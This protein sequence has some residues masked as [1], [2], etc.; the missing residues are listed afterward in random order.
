M[1]ELIL[2][3]LS[4]CDSFFKTSLFKFQKMLIVLINIIAVL[5]VLSSLLTVTVSMWQWF[6]NPR[7]STDNDG[8]KSKISRKF[9]GATAAGDVTILISRRSYFIC[10]AIRQ[11]NGHLPGGAKKISCTLRLSHWQAS[12]FLKALVAQEQQ[13]RLAEEEVLLSWCPLCL[14]YR[15][16]QK[17]EKTPKS[18]AALSR[19]RAWMRET[20]NNT[21]AVSNFIAAS[22]LIFSRCGA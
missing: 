4:W 21:L 7:S 14:I 9:V 17:K 13:R 16:R 15:G 5:L 22:I 11:G 12:C 20:L 2:F 3:I 1:T 6:G 10:A 8:G 19:F 18:L